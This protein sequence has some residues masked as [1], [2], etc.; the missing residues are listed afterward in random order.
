MSFNFHSRRHRKVPG[1]ST[2]A[3]ADISFILLVF[4]LMVTSMD[5]D[6]G[7]PRQLPSKDEKKVEKITEIDRRNVLEIALRADGK[8]YCNDEEAPEG[9]I[10]GRAEQFIRTCPQPRKHILSLDIADDADYEGYFQLQNKLILAYRQVRETEAQRRYHTGF[11]NLNEGQQAKIRQQFPQRIAEK[12][13][14]P[15]TP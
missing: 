1:L 8:V 7:L 5:P 3:T 10:Q 14:K 2:T 13:S 11:R 4:F 12:P 15:Q 9:D 6:K